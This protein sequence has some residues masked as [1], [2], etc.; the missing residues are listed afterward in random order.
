MAQ[1]DLKNYYGT[2]LYS[3][4]ARQHPKLAG[5]I[6]GMFLE[7]GVSEFDAN[8]E[9]NGDKNVFLEDLCS[10]PEFLEDKIKEALELLESSKNLE[11]VGTSVR[12]K[13][14][15][16]VFAGLTISKVSTQ[17]IF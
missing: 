4:V 10:N 17:N 14:G 7:A 11:K 5:K 6:T 13:F 12:K 9:I 16:L 15:N 2:Q 1:T 3:I 8:S